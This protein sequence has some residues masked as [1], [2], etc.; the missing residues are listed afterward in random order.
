MDSE[1]KTS[2]RY[3]AGMSASGTGGGGGNALPREMGLNDLA[4]E[5]LNLVVDL[6]KNICGLEMRLSPICVEEQKLNN[7]MEDGSEIRSESER[8]DSKL[9]N[10]IRL[11][12]RQ[13]GRIVSLERSVNI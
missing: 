9:K 12:N 13:I 8:P 3:G 4:S 5:V 1:Q 6:E 11:L 7:R 2:P 10:T